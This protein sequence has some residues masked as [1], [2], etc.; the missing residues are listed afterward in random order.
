MNNAILIHGMPSKEEY[1]SNE[2]PTMSNSHWFPWISKEL[3][4][5]D[6]FTVAVE[7]PN[8]YAPE[9]GV[10]KREFERFDIDETTILI[11]HSCGGGFLV[12]YFSEHPHLRV[13]HIILVAP[14]IN[15]TKEERAGNFFDFIIRKGIIDQASKFTIIA[16]DN[17]YDTITKSVDILRNELP[18]VQYIELKG[19]QHF[20]Y[21]DLGTEEFPELLEEIIT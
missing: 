15:P 6:I 8:S 10:W 18:G 14:W 7:I 2:Y 19:K 20:T 5:R 9:Y 1:Y 13:R 4:I 11:G 16:S 21:N 17:D 12:R 3:Q